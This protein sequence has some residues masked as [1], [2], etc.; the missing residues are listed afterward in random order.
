MNPTF[1]IGI[2]TCDRPEFFDH[3]INSIRF[4]HASHLII[5]NSGT[6][7]TYF[8]P[9]FAVK[10]K[11]LESKNDQKTP[12]SIASGKNHIVQV[13]LESTQDDFL[14]IIEDDVRV[15]NPRIFYDYI[16]LSLESGLQ[17]LIWGGGGPNNRRPNKDPIA[18]HQIEYTNG[19]VAVFYKHCVGMFNLYSRKLLEKIGGFDEKFVNSMEHVDHSYRAVKEGFLPAYGVWPDLQD[20][21]ECLFDQDPDFEKS[22]MK[23][24]SRV[25]VNVADAVKYFIEKHGFSPYNF[26]TIEQTDLALRLSKIQKIFTA[27]APG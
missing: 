27:Q 8:S 7:D 24:K 5:V 1:S 15:V 3:C 18:I 12:A 2:L 16:E 6:H 14:Y 26:P 23:E 19:Q 22:T 17:H 10:S 9:E 20:S 21:N 11:I 4:V 13:F 25:N